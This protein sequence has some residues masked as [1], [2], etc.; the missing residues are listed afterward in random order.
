[1]AHL[2]V[3]LRPGLGR[4]C[5]SDDERLTVDSTHSNTLD[6]TGGS[7]HERHTAEY[8]RVRPMP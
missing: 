5:S 6:D 1:M 7:R 4:P 3:E 2:Q 8:L